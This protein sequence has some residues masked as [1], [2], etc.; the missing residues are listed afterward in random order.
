MPKASA[1][2]KK[3]THLSP[4]PVFPCI[5]SWTISMTHI[6]L[7]DSFDWLTPLPLK[8]STFVVNQ[9]RHP[10]HKVKK[11][12]IGTYKVIPWE[13]C[14]TTME[15]VEKLRAEVKDVQIVSIE[16][17]DSAV[18][19]SSIE[20]KAPCA[21]I[22]GNE[23]TGISEDVMKASDYVAYLPM[24]GYNTSMNVIVSGAIAA[25]HIHRELFK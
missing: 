2:W 4:S 17:D 14:A 6:I 22:L 5:L 16:L 24:F 9:K 10:N 3:I 11:A 15:A 8:K 23:T 19:Y 7:V 18:L 25:Y 12:S 21:V 13:Y 20:Y 1:L